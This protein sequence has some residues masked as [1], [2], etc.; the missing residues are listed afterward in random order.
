[1]NVDKGCVYIAS[2]QT[3]YKKIKMDDAKTRLAHAIF[4][5]EK[6]ISNC[7]KNALTVIK[8]SITLIILELLIALAPHHK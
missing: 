8:K 4:N 7:A 1:M 3:M 5:V 6:S 2:V